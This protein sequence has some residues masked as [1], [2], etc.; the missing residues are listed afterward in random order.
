MHSCNG[1]LQW[2]WVALVAWVAGCSSTPRYKI[3]VKYSVSDP[4][5]MQTMGNLLGPP[6]I[7]GNATTTLVNGDRIFPPMLDA[8]AHARRNINMETYVYWEGEVGKRFSDA[9]AE[10]AAAGVAVHLI[11]DAVGASDIDPKY[12][13][14]MEKGGVHIVVFNPLKWYDWTTAAK[15][16]HRTHRKLLIVDG[17]VAFTGGVGIADE[18]MG[19]ADTPEHFRDDHYLIRGPA[20]LQL[21]SVFADNW[22]QNT[23]VVLHGK[24]YFPKIEAVGPEWAQV[25]KSSPNS[26]GETMELMYQL[27]IAA[28][29]KNIR[30][31][32]AYF[33]PDQQTIDLLLEARQRGVKIQFIVPGHYIDEPVVRP[34][35]RDLWGPLLKAG[36]E[37][38]E[39]E[40]T[41]FHCKQMMVDGLWSSI[42]SANFDNR[43]FKLNDECNLNI[44]DARFTSEQEMIFD[45]DLAKSKRI[46]FEQ[47][48]ARPFHEKV[49][50][51][52]AGW[53]SALL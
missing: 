32:T 43:S 16:N 15:V 7:S 1:R 14:K 35:S 4:E 2:I 39:Y 20:V 27:S 36:I 29:K 41:M 12:I 8:I 28:A 19:D 3:E 40:P 31:A 48:K 33:V 49:A 50:D 42:G 21:Q 17:E 6:L 24:D 22:M 9:L 34:A 13:R 5:F 26:G 11:I 45:Q 25:F 18:W 51:F 10:R 46:T 47:W 38:Y 23:G 30:I 52:L 44:L 53:F 37:I